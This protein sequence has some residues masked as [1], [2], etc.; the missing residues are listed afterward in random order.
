VIVA[1]AV[2]AVAYYVTGASATHIPGATYT[3]TH[4]GGGVLY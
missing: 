4:S 3:G 1:V 2:V